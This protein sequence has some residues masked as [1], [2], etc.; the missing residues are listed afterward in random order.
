RLTPLAAALLAATTVLT[1]TG[2]SEQLGD[3]PL[4][5]DIPIVELDS[6]KVYRNIDGFPNITRACADGIAFAVTST[7]VGPSMVRVPE[8]DAD[9]AS[10]SDPG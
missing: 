1:L 3:R 8:W 7:D 4:T 2:C 5:D 9:C 6:I 10:Q